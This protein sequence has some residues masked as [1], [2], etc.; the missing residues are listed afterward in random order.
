MLSYL[1]SCF[2]KKKVCFLTNTG[3]IL[4]YIQMVPLA[5]AFITTPSV[6]TAATITLTSK[7]ILAFIDI[8]CIT[9]RIKGDR[10]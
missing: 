8:W 9:K 6:F 1:S 10:C 7:V 2:Q 5:L 4:L 3:I